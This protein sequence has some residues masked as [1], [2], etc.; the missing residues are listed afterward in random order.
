MNWGIK[1]DKELKILLVLSFVL[2]IF[3]LELI[4]R[5][6]EEIINTPMLGMFEE[7]CPHPEQ[8]PGFPSG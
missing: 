1:L 5:D 6:D 8:Q 4:F 7:F 3:T 2:A